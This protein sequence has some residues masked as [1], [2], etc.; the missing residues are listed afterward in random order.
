MTERNKKRLFGCFLSIL[1]AIFISQVIGMF[2]DLSVQL[3]YLVFFVSLV[4]SLLF[5]FAVSKL[6]FKSFSKR[7]ESPK[8][9]N[10]DTPQNQIQPG[11]Q[12]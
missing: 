5:G 2:F 7:I 4:V 8:S 10:S 1:L 12:L 3:E 9:V 6:V 11:Q